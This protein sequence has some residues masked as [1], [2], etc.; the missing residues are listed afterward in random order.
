MN[1]CSFRSERFALLYMVT[2][3]KIVWRTFIPVN[4]I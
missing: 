3:A 4:L 2:R 1:L